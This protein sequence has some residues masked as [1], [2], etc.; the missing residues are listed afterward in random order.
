MIKAVIFDC[1]GVLVTNSWG[2]FKQRYF[3]HDPELMQQATDLMQQA[4]AG[5]IDWPT[6][7]QA[8]AKLTGLSLDE[9]NRQLDE[10]PSNEPL[11]RLIESLKADYKIGMLSNAADNWL[12]TLF[13]PD[14]LALF[15]ATALSYDIGFMKPQ[16]GAYEL[17]AERLDV[18]PKECVFVDDH[19]ELCTAAKDTGM[20]AVW[21]RDFDQFKSDIEKIL[22]KAA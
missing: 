20:Q 9:V 11:F 21:Y 13:T 15:D 17:A 12:S 4:D 3:G 6:T 5:F 1:F 10:T 7:T 18:L 2:P 8:L 19:E 22:S 14:Q 16:L